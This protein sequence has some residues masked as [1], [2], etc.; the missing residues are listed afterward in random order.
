M[1]LPGGGGGGGGALKAEFLNEAAKAAR[2]EYERGMNLLLLLGGSG[3]SPEFFS[4]SMY[5]RTNF[6]PF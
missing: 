5:L 3:G 2:G 4:K 1:L 6:K